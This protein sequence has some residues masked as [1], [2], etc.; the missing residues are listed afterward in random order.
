MSDLNACTVRQDKTLRDA[1]L[2]LERGCTGIA[3]VVDGQNRLVGTLTDGDVRR[4]LLAGNG[5]DMPLAPFVHRGFTAVGPGVSRMHVLDVMQARTIEQVPILDGEGHLIGLHLIHELLGAVERPNWAVIMAGGQGTRLRP[6]TEHVPKPMLKVAGRPILERLVLH[7]VGFGIKRIYLSIHYLG[8]QIEEHFED[9][10]RF[11]CRI[12]YLREEQPLGTGG[13][14]TLL[15]EKPQQ[16]LIVMNGDL[17]TQANLNDMLT[18]HNQGGQVATLGVRR[19][20]HYVPFGCVE[21]DGNRLLKIEEKPPISR[22]I[23]CGIYVLEPRL[24]E[25]IPKA[26]F[27]LPNLLDDCIQDGNQVAIFEIA[28]DWID[29]GQHEQLRDARQGK[30]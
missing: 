15:P 8:H 30:E 9:G 12:E 20:V 17:V 27:A 24:L 10:S 23:N 16:P 7:L 2:A 13:A 22:L 1:L 3:L 29:V 11:G 6:Y 28:D 21:V 26:P 5:L 25:R 4:A 14:L 19:Y 18:Y